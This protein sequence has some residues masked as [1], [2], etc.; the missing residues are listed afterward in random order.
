MLQPWGQMGVGTGSPAFLKKS[1]KK[2][3]LVLATGVFARTALTN[4]SF[5]AAFFTK[6]EKLAA[7]H[8]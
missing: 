4:K 1:S 6:K 8:V 2:L 5:F 3:L 7:F